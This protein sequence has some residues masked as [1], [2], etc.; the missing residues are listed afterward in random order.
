M[1]PSAIGGAMPAEFD[2][3]IASQTLTGAQPVVLVVDDQH[4]NVRMV[5]ALLARSGYAVLPAASGAEGL[6]LARSHVPD[7]VLLDMKMPG[8]D[9]FEVLRQM[10]LDKATDRKSV[11]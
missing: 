2:I 8:M 5:G 7:V 10:R 3:D 11:V 6:E 4:A 1:N 9:G